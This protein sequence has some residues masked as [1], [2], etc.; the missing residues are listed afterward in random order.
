MRCARQ[1]RSKFGPM[2]NP[3]TGKP[4]FS[5][6]KFT[7]MQTTSIRMEKEKEKLGKLIRLEVISLIYK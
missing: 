4:E 5:S 2:H 7:L 3:F 1:E 6:C